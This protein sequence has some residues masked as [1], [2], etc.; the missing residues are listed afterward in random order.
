MRIKGL[1]VLKGIRYF[2]S[3]LCLCGAICKDAAHAEPWPYVERP[4]GPNY[5]L[6]D[7]DARLGHENLL[8]G[9]FGNAEYHFRRAVEVT[10]QNGAAWLGLAS[11]Y[12]RL[13]RFDL[14][15]RAYKS[16][17]RFAGDNVA[18]LNNHGYSYLLRGRMREAARLL[19]RAA[20]LDPENPTVANNIRMLRAGQS[21]FW[22]S[23]PYIWG[24][25]H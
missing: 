8:A 25:P 1:T 7:E 5:Y 14:A 10:P 4:F 2:F 6:G 12:D 11:C 3:I 22:G 24:W 18:V 13:G 15:E 21:Y 19:N 17:E 9:N 20:Q 16:A 23:A